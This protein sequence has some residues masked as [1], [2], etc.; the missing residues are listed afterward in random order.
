MDQVEKISVSTPDRPSHR[1]FWPQGWW[2]ILDFKIGIVPVPVYL[3]L[4][5]LIVA[6]VQIGNGKVASDLLTSIAILT[7]GGFTCGEIGKR[8]PVIKHLGAAAIFA[9]FLPSYLV[10]AHLL[11]EPVIASTKEFFQVSN[12][13]YLYICCIIVGSIL[14]M[15]RASLIRGAVKIFVPLVS[16]LLV[17]AGAGTLMGT[18]LGLGT[19]HTFFY[20]IVPM[21][22]GGVG[23]GVIPI[24][25]GYALIK[26]GNQGVILAE[27]LPMVMMSGF[28]CVVF[29]ALLDYYGK[30]K[31]RLT[32]NG[33]ITPGEDEIAD[34]KSTTAGPID[35]TTVA[36]TGVTAVALYLIGVL[37]QKMFNF[38]APLSMI[39]LAFF[40][41]AVNAISPQLQQGGQ[42]IQKFFA[43]AVTYPLLFAVGVSLTP[44]DKLVGA[45]TILNIVVIVFTVAVLM[46][47]GFLVA[48][49]INMYPIDVAV[50]CSCSAAQGGTGD[51]AI[52]TAANRLTLLPFCSIATRLGG[53]SMVSTALILMRLLG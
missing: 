53:A 44:W 16:G 35:A 4:I 22:G 2:R 9:T 32:G 42:I 20:I 26:G 23:E 21:M 18:L 12:F 7:V 24:S 6:F 52:L 39:F 30:L 29:S 15:D 36:A 33:R 19:Y 28:T 27:I 38:P 8:L 46:T 41:K 50:V 10:Y 40:M 49:L 47:T 43:T 31:P 1:D 48:R 45:F 25:I 3:I 17:A 5:L 51:V 14:G 34:V 13:L 37:G 11:P